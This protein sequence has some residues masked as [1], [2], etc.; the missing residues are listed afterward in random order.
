MTNFLSTVFAVLAIAGTG[1]VVATLAALLTTQRA[2]L[3]NTVRP[4]AGWLALSAATTA[5]AGSLYYSEIAGFEPCQLC[6]VQRIFM[7]PSAA[8]LALAVFLPRERLALV[9]MF[10]SVLGLPVSLFHRF[11]QQFPD[12]A[13]SCSLDNP[14]SGR[15]VNVFGFITIPTMAAVAFAL[16]IVSTMIWVSGVDHP[17]HEDS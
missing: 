8:I 3:L 17:V 11:E 16:V 5:T 10:L 15:W 9:A 7:Y 1:F 6:W 2:R 12:S 4:F 13:S 14:C